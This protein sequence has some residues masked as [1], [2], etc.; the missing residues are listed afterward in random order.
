MSEDAQSGYA[1]ALER[2]NRVDP[3][4][5]EARAAETLADL[6]AGAGAAVSSSWPACPAAK[7]PASIW[8]P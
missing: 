3:G 6:G 2:F 5:F 4:G 8:P 1:L 7:R